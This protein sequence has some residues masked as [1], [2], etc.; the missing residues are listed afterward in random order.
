LL[1]MRWELSED[2][3]EIRDEFAGWLDHIA[4]SETLRSW[5]AAGPEQFEAAFAEAGWSALGIPEGAGGAG[6]GVLSLALAA[7]AMGRNGVPS[8]R[9]LATAVALPA[10]SGRPEVLEEVAAGSGVALTVPAGSAPD[11]VLASPDRL[12]TVTEGVLAGRIELVL[13]GEDALVVPARAGERVVLA[14]V[15]AGADGVA[16]HPRPMLDVTRSAVDVVLDGVAVE[17]LDVDAAAV[18]TECS[19]R[20]AVLVAADALGA[21]QRMLDLAVT[22]SGQREQF[23]VPI[24]SFQ[25]V[26]HAAATILVGI[27]AARSITYPAAAAL[28]DEHELAL[29]WACAAKAQVGASAVAAAD[30]S[31]TM[32]GAIGYTFEHDLHRFYKRAKLDAQLF[33]SSAQWNERLASHLEL[34]RRPA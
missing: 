24:G 25:A 3:A 21:S 19:L 12:P 34:D 10:L 17:L 29:P 27:E 7:E 8:G 23:G 28:D 11:A 33:G 5:D 22:Y 20:A 32:H 31:L 18:L 9:W 14:F 26:K 13:G 4:S 2:Q 6:G 1:D 30:S 16:R 15:P